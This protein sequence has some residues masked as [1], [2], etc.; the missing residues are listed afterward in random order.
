MR[1][2]KICLLVAV[3]LSAPSYAAFR[4]VDEKGRTHIGDTPPQACA[5]VVMYEVTRSGQVLRR[6]DPPLTEEQAKAKADAEE[7][8]RVAAKVAAEQKRLDTALL[9]T[10]GNEK[11]FDIARD[12]NVEPLKGRIAQSNDRMKDIDK[13][14]KQV[15]EEMEFY[16]AGKKKGAKGKEDAAAPM[17]AELAR[18]EDEKKTMQ[19][20]IAGFEREIVELNRKYDVDKRRWIALKQGGGKIAGEEPG[21]EPAKAAKK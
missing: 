2:N 15:K 17:A 13:R 9:S 20:N 16:T 14:V 8:A 3:T 21:A 11:E 19:K 12:R 6:M 1:T 5:N 4:C 7:K 18:L 10:Y